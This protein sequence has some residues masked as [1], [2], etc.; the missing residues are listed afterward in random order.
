MLTK[1]TV[2]V[3]EDLL[4]TA[5]HRAIDE[6]VFLQELVSNALREYLKKPRPTKAAKTRTEDAR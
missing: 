5:R 1:V 6:K 4:S 2:R 3:E